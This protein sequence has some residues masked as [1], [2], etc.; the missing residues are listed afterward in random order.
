MV[1]FKTTIKTTL[2][3]LLNSKHVLSIRNA[4]LDLEILCFIWIMMLWS[5]PILASKSIQTTHFSFHEISGEVS[6]LTKPPYYSH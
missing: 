2:L 3:A 4:V 6:Y 5:S 1:K